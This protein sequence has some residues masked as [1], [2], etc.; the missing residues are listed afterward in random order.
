MLSGLKELQSSE[1]ERWAEMGSE[2]GPWECRRQLPNLG[3]ESEKASETPSFFCHPQ[4]IGE[5]GI[6]VDG[7]LV[8][9]HC[10]T[11]KQAV[12]HPWAE[13]PLGANGVCDEPHRF[14]QKDSCQRISLALGI[15]SSRAWNSSQDSELTRLS[16][17]SSI[18][19]FIEI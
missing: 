15:S 6:K 7:Q 12:S 16:I 10:R 13:W 19:S 1:E 5:D 8:Y 17:R 2:R 11:L 3:V 14:L 9:G 4:C 18:H